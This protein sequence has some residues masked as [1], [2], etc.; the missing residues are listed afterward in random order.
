MGDARRSFSFLVLAYNHEK[1]IIEHLESIKYLVNTHGGNIN[2]D[3]I[4]NDDASKDLTAKL[5]TEW[6]RV[7]QD[8]FRKTYFLR[9]K[10]NIGTCH[11]I[12]NMLEYISADAVKLTAGDDVYS[13][14][15]I[16]DVAFSCNAYTI[17]S[18]IPLDLTD[19]ILSENK[20]DTFNSV[21]CDV[22][23]KNVS[24]T[25]RYKHLS[26]NNAPNIIYPIEFLQ[27]PSTKEFLKKYDVV[28]DWPLQIAFSTRYPQAQHE[29]KKTVLVYYRRT[30]GSTYIVA[31]KRFIEDK[32]KV[33]DYLLSIELNV[34]ERFRLSIRKWCF[35]KSNK[36]L[37]KLLNIDF[38]CYVIN[39]FLHFYKI[40]KVAKNTDMKLIEHDL[41]Y[42]KIK[43][44]SRDFHNIM[45]CMK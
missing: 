40:F 2:V 8:I 41:F 24:L 3:L 19:G 35:V 21:A 16:F 38:Y 9:N 26:Y 31:N 45:N 4:I 10:E 27:E 28:E 17:I 36:I 39:V 13:F 43:A 15:N 29:L 32:I 37:N 34:I 25:H 6:L 22:I 20:I 11:S 12:C 33:Y 44:A 18:G 23:Y 42:K 7:N 5:I 14:E 1:Y 30:L